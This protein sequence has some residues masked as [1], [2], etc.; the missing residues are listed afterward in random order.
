[1]PVYIATLYED[2][3]M[4]ETKTGSIDEVVEWADRVMHETGA[5]EL[6]IKRGERE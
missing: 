3:R 4:T 1:M 6:R 2:G 5:N